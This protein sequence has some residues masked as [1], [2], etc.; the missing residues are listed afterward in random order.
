MDKTGILFFS[1]LKNIQGNRGLL[2]GLLGFM[3]LILL[4]S[5]YSKAGIKNGVLSLYKAVL[6]NSQILLQGLFTITPDSSAY[7][8]DIIIIKKEGIC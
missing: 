4:I 6:I 1:E 5:C 2:L 8:L 3:V 7:P